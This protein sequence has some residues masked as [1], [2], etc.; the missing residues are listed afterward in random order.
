MKKLLALLLAF[1]L[2]FTSFS[3]LSEAVAESTEALSQEEMDRLMKEQMQQMLDEA[4]E[5][6]RQAVETKRSTPL[7][8]GLVY[9]DCVSRSVS[10]LGL[11]TIEDVIAV[12]ADE[13][14]VAY[15]SV[16]EYYGV[17]AQSG[18]LTMPLITM[19]DGSLTVSRENGA[20]V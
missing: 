11:L 9:V 6:T 14:S 5:Q 19:E 10:P 1:C 17:L 16:R 2:C 12:P 3:A 4:L 13:P 7:P 8:E 18:L 15:V 20:T